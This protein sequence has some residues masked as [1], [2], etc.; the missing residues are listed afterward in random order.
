[1]TYI[2]TLCNC[3]TF[4]NFQHMCDSGSSQHPLS[5]SSNTFDVTMGQTSFYSSF[6]EIAGHEKTHED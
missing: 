2:V 4:Q 1:M 3:K 6:A 5:F